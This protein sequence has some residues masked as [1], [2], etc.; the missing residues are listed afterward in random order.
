MSI[1]S[2][3]HVCIKTADLDATAAFYCGALGLEKLFDFTRK[4]QRIGY[5]LKTGNLSFI[6][7]FVADAID[8]VGPKQ[9]LSHLCLESGDLK[10]LRERLL[11]AGHAPGPI[12]LAADNTW[13]FWMKDPNGMDVEFQ[14]YT[15][16]PRSSPAHRW[17]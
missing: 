1:K 9:V 4:G 5:Y 10:G 3:A 7:V 2:L 17:K 6:E 13:Q 15:D 12:H 11:A 14:E 8:P 16:R